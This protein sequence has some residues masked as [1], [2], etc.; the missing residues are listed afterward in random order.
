[1]AHKEQIR[2]CK[3]VRRYFPD[4]FNNVRVLDI[5][6]LDI[7]GNNRYLFKNSE[8]FG[9]D[10]IK[11][12][13][14]NLVCPVYKYCKK[15]YYDIVISTEMLEHDMFAEKSLKAMIDCLRPGGLLLITAAYGE[16]KEHG[17]YLHNPQ[18]SPATLDFYKNVTEEMFTNL[19]LN[20]KHIETTKTDL[21]FYGFKRD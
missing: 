7:N 10:L 20:Y 17:T 5:G 21:Y 16:R 12:K 13:N 15:D 11:G 14:V 1:M 6:S 4:Y 8:Y 18:D 2:F 19:I 9:I 3:K